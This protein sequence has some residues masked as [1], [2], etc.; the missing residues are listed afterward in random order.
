MRMAIS[1]GLVGALALLAAFVP[2]VPASAQDAACQVDTI[3]RPALAEHMRTASQSHG[4][5]N[6]VATTNWTRFQSALY[7]GLVKEAM[8]RRPEGGVV[9]IPSEAM[10]WEFYTL[11]GLTDTNLMP[12]H[13]LWALHL[14]VTTQLAYRPDGIIQAVEK[15]GTPNL[16][17]NVR[18]GWPD[19]EDG[20]DK[21]GF[22]DTL[23]VPKLKV[24]NRQ[25]ITIRMLE[26]DDMVV[27][28]KIEGASGR[29]LS[30]LLGAIF[31]VIGE[32]NLKYSRS[33]FAAD[34]VQVLRAQAK[35]MFS[36]T[37]TVTVSPDG[38]AEKG[39]PDDRADLAAMEERLK[40]DLKIAY[41]PYRCW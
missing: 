30:G 21:Y 15:G 37:A 36:K 32:G 1:L 16:A 26:F 9:L 31:K 27:Y 13:L 14:G 29:P 38:T 19:R 4:R 12:A 6:F 11:S 28:D 10:F 8:A 24:T 22:I 17:I 3:S 35:K 2:V 18:V 5:F 7:L 33:T 20:Q 40:L 41:H 25:V 39:V 34:G 23:S